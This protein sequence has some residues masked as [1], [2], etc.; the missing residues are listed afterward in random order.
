MVPDVPK[1]QVVVCVLE[2]DPD[3]YSACG[4]YID[5]IN[6]IYQPDYIML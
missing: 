5:T 3:A 1:S 2:D 6:A 4:E